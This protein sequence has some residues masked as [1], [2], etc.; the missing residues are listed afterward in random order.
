MI[1]LAFKRP[2][3]LY[4]NLIRD[5]TG[6]EFGHV[7]LI[8]SGTPEKALCYSSRESPAA[9]ERAGTDITTLD[10]SDELI[11][12]LLEMPVMLGTENLYWFCRGSSGRPYDYIGIA[13]IGTD[14]S[15]LHVGA[16][17]FCSNECTNTLQQVVAL[18]PGINPWMVAP[19]GFQNQH[20]RYGLYEMCVSAGWAGLPPMK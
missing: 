13:G 9:G 5:V 8:L 19:S 18:W 2:T 11:W 14:L 4:S 1:G 10:L 6:G 3:G 17:R 20:G 16:A 7:E 12:K 15:H